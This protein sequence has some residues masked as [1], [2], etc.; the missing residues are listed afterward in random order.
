MFAGP[1]QPAEGG[2]TGEPGVQRGT[3]SFAPRLLRGGQS[4]VENSVHRRNESKGLKTALAE[5]TV[6][7]PGPIPQH[8]GDE[9]APSPFWDS[10]PHVMWLTFKI[11]LF[12]LLDCPRNVCSG[13]LPAVQRA[14]V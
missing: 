1:F 10:W 4:C 3:A 2:G 14:R 7:A 5:R 8:V 11:L 6:N 12:F 13:N 9:G